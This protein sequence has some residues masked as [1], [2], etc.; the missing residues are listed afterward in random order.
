MTLCATCQAESDRWLESSPSEVLP[1]LSIAYGSGAA[2]DTTGA[3]IRQRRS[4]RWQQWRDLVVFQRNL[5]REGCASGHHAQPE[6]T[7]PDA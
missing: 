2:Y 3:G 6:R 5:I 4:A 7:N 1:L